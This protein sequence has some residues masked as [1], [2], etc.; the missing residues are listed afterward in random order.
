MDVAFFLKEKIYFY[1][2]FLCVFNQNLYMMSNIRRRKK[3]K[4]TVVR[5]RKRVKSS[6]NNNNKSRFPK[7][8]TKDTRC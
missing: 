7:D 4:N 2:M 6:H 1:L 5:E 8:T 3:K